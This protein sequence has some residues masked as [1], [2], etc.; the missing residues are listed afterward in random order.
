[1]NF[2]PEPGRNST[3]GSFILGVDVNERAKYIWANYMDVLRNV[4]NTLKMK[5]ID[6]TIISIEIWDRDLNVWSD[7]D[8]PA[9]AELAAS[10][11]R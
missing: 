6:S 7:E 11:S 1:M 10:P 5:E 9:N 2:F 8:L 3:R 4:F